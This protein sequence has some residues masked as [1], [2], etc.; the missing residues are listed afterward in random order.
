VSDAPVEVSEAGMSE[1]RVPCAILV[2]FMTGS[3]AVAADVPV[4]EGPQGLAAY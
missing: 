3:A 2:I 1:R 4:F